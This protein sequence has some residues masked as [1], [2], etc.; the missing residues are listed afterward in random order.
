[1]TAREAAA[2]RRIAGAAS[3][4]APAMLA[5]IALLCGCG[6]NGKAKPKLAI[7]RPSAPVIVKCERK[8]FDARSILGFKGA[9]ARA[10]FERRG[11]TMRAIEKRGQPIA[12][13][14]GY[15]SGRV[16]VGIAQEHVVRV[17]GES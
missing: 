12:H 4:A 9:D 11:C 8:T 2:P 3:R 10:A 5:S 15:V 6:G 1:V 14:S 13:P 16:D 7:V 17:F